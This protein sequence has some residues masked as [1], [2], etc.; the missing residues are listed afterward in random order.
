MANYVNKRTAHRW[1]TLGLMLTAVFFAFG[2]FWLLQAIQSEDPAVSGNALNE[3]DYIVENF[4]F[5]RMTESGSPRY[6][7]S[8]ERLVHHPENDVSEVTRPVV[9][10]MVP[11]RPRMTMNADRGEV[12]HGENRV[13]LMGKVDIVRPATPK[14][15][16][17]RARTDALTVLAD[18]EIVKTN[19]PVQ[20]TLGAA[21]VDAVGMVAENPTQ[22]L[23]LGGRGQIVYPPRQRGASTQ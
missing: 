13:E 22:K 9:E 11:G 1:R 8:G 18:D 5:V 20:M 4:S 14:S 23:H 7:M 15:E 16:A 12:F 17:L 19:R 21:K 3:P 10:S 6:V 2:S